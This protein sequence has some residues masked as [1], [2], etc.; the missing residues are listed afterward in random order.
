MGKFK[1][2]ETTQTRLD[3]YGAIVTETTSKSWVIK[4]D[5]EPFF[6]TYLNSISWIY[7]LNSITTIKVLYKLLERS[8]FN[9][10]KVDI[11][12]KL[13]KNICEQLDITPPTLS[14]SIKQLLDLKVL[15]EDDDAYRIDEK[16]F[17]KGDYKTREQ[18]LKANCTITIT[19][20]YDFENNPEE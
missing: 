8:N 18:L 17:W 6:L 4:K 5:T 15:Y 7:G 12:T 2:T 3:E 19:P 11:S 9:S 13:R 1:V 16:L 14:K 20:D 10:N